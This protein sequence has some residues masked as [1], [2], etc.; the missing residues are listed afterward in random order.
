MKLHLFSLLGALLLVGTAAA[1]SAPDPAKNLE[2]DSRLTKPVTLFRPRIF[3]GDLLKVL[4]SETGASIRC[5]PAEPSMGSLELTIGWPEAP[6]WKLLDALPSLLLNSTARWGWSGDG[7]KR[8]PYTLMCSRPLVETARI[9]QAEVDRTF[10]EDVAIMIQGAGLPPEE[11]ERFGE[12][13]PDQASRLSNEGIVA[14]VRAFASLPPEIRQRVL[15]GGMFRVYLTDAPEPMKEL[16]RLRLARARPGELGG[17]PPDSVLV[18]GIKQ[19]DFV[20]AVGIQPG[21][22]GASDYLGGARVDAMAGRSL[23]RGWDRDGDVSLPDGPPLEGTH[24][25]RSGRWTTQQFLIWIARTYAVPLVSDASMRRG[26]VN[27]PLIPSGSS[28][29]YCLDH[30]AMMGSPKVTLKQRNGVVLIRYWS[31]YRSAAYGQVPFRTIEMLRKEFDTERPDARRVFRALSPL[32][33]A[34]PS[35]IQFL[36][37]YFPVVRLVPSVRPALIL[38]VGESKRRD[39]LFAPG[40]IRVADLSLNTRNRLAA[41][42]AEAWKGLHK[43]AQ[44]ARSLQLDYRLDEQSVSLGYVLTTAERSLR[45]MPKLQP[46]DPA[47]PLFIGPEQT[48][49]PATMEEPPGSRRVRPDSLPSGN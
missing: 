11:R 47:L 15:S 32:G 16:V 9:A 30:V 41:L 7:S 37:H 27:F 2:G 43:F 34:D 44:E 22:M 31:W 29:R 33:D 4:E 8:S 40:G 36:E 46:G 13:H 25:L 45:H 5:S 28:L 24:P 23:A 20:R 12:A 48:E 19:G 14:G 49:E 38:Y 3:L 39:A 6:A 42:P 17:S 26:V 18:A 10:E 21:S 35:V 1:A